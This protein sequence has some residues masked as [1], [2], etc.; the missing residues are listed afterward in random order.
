VYWD[1]EIWREDAVEGANFLIS[2]KKLQCV[3][4]LFTVYTDVE[5]WR[6]DAVEGADFLIS[7]KLQ[8]VAF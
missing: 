8:G 1:V 6:E 3:A 4:F 2:A 5:I 7:A